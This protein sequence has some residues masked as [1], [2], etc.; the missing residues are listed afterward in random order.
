MALVLPQGQISIAGNFGNRTALQARFKDFDLAIANIFLPGQGLGGSATGTLDYAQQ[1]SAFPTATTRIAVNNFTRTSLSAVSDPVSI[2]MEG[3][4]ASGGGDLRALIR[5]NGTALGRAVVTL[6]SA[7]GGGWT[8][9]L[10]R[11]SLGGGVRYNGPASVLFSF[12]GQADQQLTG[13]IALAADFSGQANDPRF[14]GLVRANDLRYENETFGTQVTNMQLDGRF[15]RD[16]LEIRRF[17]GRAGYG[18]VQASGRVSLSAASGFPMDIRV[19]LDRARLARSDALGTVVTGNISITNSPAAG[20]LVS[21]DLQ[22]PELRYQIIRQGGAEIRELTGVHRKGEALA[23]VNARSAS[24]APPSLFK[25]N[26]RVRADNQ[27]FV[28]GMGLESEWKTDM[29]ITGTT[30][31][32]IVVGGL[33]VIRGTYSFSGRR[34]ELTKGNIRFGGSDLYN[35]TISISASTTVEGVSAIL[36][37]TGTAQRPEIAFTSTPSLPQD[38]VLSRILFGS[39]V[40]N[41]SATQA[42][43]LAAALNGLRGSGGGLN[44][45]GKLQGAS[46]IDR[47]RILGADNATGRGTALAAGQYITNNVYVEIITD[48]RGFTATQLEVAL[49][50]ALSVLSQT[51]GATGT[52]V[53]MRY[54]KDY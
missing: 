50:K 37:V 23:P 7:G 25:L 12:A 49:S 22:L 35:P 18:T 33:D 5:K 4:L 13:G 9:Q 54:S 47:L 51:G 32:P 29:R 28:S 48:A 27:I 11:G 38:E 6:R 21:G 16:L 17:N 44:P 2:T 46:G 53:N 43:Q 1:G 34:F 52:S 31:K 24:N 14:N 42:I 8:D 20:A 41:L 30:A 10:M 3:K 26:I 39:N 15:S 45:L 36:N 40:S 19:A